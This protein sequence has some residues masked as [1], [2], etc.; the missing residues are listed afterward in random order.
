M[1]EKLRAMDRIKIEGLP[2]PEDLS[3][4]EKKGIFGGFFAFKRVRDNLERGWSSR[5]DVCFGSQSV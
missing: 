1:I 5:Y 3:E 2:V 4:K